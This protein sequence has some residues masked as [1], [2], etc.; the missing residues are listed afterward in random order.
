MLADWG[1]IMPARG[2]GS[3]N[4]LRADAS[5]PLDFRVGRDTRGR[6]AFQLDAGAGADELRPDDP[7]A[8]MEVSVDDIGGG[9]SRLTLTLHDHEDFEIFRVLCADLLEVTRGFAPDEGARARRILL[10]RL[11]QWQEVLARRRMKLLSHNEIMGLVGELLF[12]RDVMLPRFGLPLAVGCW[13]GPYGDEQDFAV[14][15]LIVEVKTQGTTADRRLRIS[16]ED[17]LDTSASRVVI[18]QQGVARCDAEEPSAVSLNGIANELIAAAGS[19]PDC[20]ARLVLG[21]DVAGWRELPEYDDY[22]LLIDR[23]YFEVSEG[24]PRITRT[25]LR[26]G[27]EDVRYRIRV[28]DCIPFRVEEAAVFRDMVA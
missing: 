28:A 15:D 4:V 24:F 6:Y 5:H 19:V 22:W 7:P 12:L 3:L 16:S 21:L 27:V 1:S 8:G 14:A 20:R 10:G 2:A 25:D 18:C 9:I 23:N 17:Q 13:R 11:R 26:S